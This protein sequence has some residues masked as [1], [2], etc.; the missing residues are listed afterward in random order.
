MSFDFAMIDVCIIGAGLAGL[1][2]ALEL[3][4][5]G[6]SA[7]I[8]EASGRIGGR[9]A[10]DHLDGFLLDRGFQILL[11][12]YPEI[13]RVL[14]VGALNLRPFDSG[15]KVWLGKDFT[16]IANP[17]EH[18]RHLLSTA[19][20]PIGSFSDKFRI[21]TLQRAL[22]S[23]SFEQALSGRE[24]STM[25][26]L[27]EFG[28]SE[29]IIAQF[30]QPFFGG[31]FF[32]NKLQT[33]SRMF[34]FLFRMFALGKA[35][36][37]AAGMEQIPLQMSSRLR[38]TTIQ[39]NAPVTAIEQQSDKV[40]VILSSG[41]E[42]VAKNVI[43]ATDWNT[44]SRLTREAIPT[45][46]SCSTTTLYFA[47]KEPPTQDAM[48]LLNGTG[49]GLINNLCVPN[50]VAP[51]YAPEGESLVSISIVGIPKT[52]DNTLREAVVKECKDWFG[53]QV[54]EW[55]F[56]RMYRIEH[57]LPCQEPP[58]LS[59]VERS[60]QLSEHIFVAGDH[61]DTASIQGA[62]VSGRRAAQL[63]A[64]QMKEK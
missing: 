26:Y 58:A 30:F 12:E 4:K 49:R 14:D 5:N 46:K 61:R 31:V 27:R 39:T 18:P 32:D 33:S 11:S 51:L 9:V 13:S 56:L 1:A 17:L 3:E 53:N 57:A 64:K 24:R 60:V 44:A 21:L 54:Q 23:L 55:R 2:A 47:A 50:I 22:T 62:L 43:I 36:L 40:S 29:R 45:I 15:A 63:L 59:I 25:Q 52:D 10:T 34:E 42:I 7:T 6:V 8:L 28:F 19:L 48:L 20:S 38:S 41:E 37:P 35:T 16:T